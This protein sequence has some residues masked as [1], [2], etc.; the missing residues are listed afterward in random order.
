M[1]ISRDASKPWKQSVGEATSGGLPPAQPF[2][3]KLAGGGGNGSRAAE[4]PLVGQRDDGSCVSLH[5]AAVAVQC[6]G[7]L[8][9]EGL[10][11]GLRFASLS[12]KAVQLEVQPGHRTRT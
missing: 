1:Q 4:A 12:Q 10:P 2:S 11:A 7:L 8:A 6:E 9:R 5:A 3:T